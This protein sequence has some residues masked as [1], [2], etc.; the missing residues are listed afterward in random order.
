MPCSG[1]P[2][3]SLPCSCAAVPVQVT[4]IREYCQG[5]NCMGYAIPGGCFDE[6][7]HATFVDCAKAELSEEVRCG[8]RE[9]G[10][11]R[12]GVRRGA[13]GDCEQ[14]HAVFVDCAQAELSEEVRCGC[15]G[16]GE[17]GMCGKRC[18]HPS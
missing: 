18:P 2:V 3:R 12:N 6:K 17:C 13:V 10:G 5:P 15:L 16:Y 7:K 8:C 9:V 1:Q 14:Q 4:L 11:V